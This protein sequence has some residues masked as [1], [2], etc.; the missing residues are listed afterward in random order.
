[1]WFN[2]PAHNS[3]TPY[4]CTPPGSSYSSFEDPLARA[5]AQ[6]RAA[7]EREAAARRRRQD[8]T[9]YPYNSYPSDDEDDG[10]FTPHPYNSY[11]NEDLRLRQDLE[12]Q[13]QLQLAHQAEL[14]GRREAEWTRNLAEH[15]YEPQEPVVRFVSL[16]TTSDQPFLIDCHLSLS[17]H[18]RF[19]SP[20]FRP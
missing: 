6:D 8:V 13:R 20:F 1:M 5:V 10:A 11:V 12:Q 9:R 14:D 19:Y 3:Y 15:V 16:Q 18:V 17:A 2:R 7:R 4:G